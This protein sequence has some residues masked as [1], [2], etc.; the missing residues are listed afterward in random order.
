MAC[1][2]Y[3]AGDV[4]GFAVD[5]S[6]NPARVTI[7]K[8]GNE[9]GT[10]EVSLSISSDE[11]IPAISFDNAQGTNVTYQTYEGAFDYAIP[12]GYEALS[13]SVGFSHTEFMS[14]LGY[15]DKTTNNP[16]EYTDNIMDFPIFKR[17]VTI[18]FES[19]SN[20][21]FG[22]IKVANYDGS[23]DHWLQRSW[24]GRGVRLYY[25]NKGWAREDFRLISSVICHEVIATSQEV[26]TLKLRDKSAL[27]SNPIKLNRYSSRTTTEGDLIPLCYGHCLQITP[28]LIDASIGKYQVHDGEI[29]EIIAVY[30]RGYEL[31]TSQYT[32]DLEAGTF[33]LLQSND[34]TI[35]CDV[36]GSK[37]PDMQGGG[38]STCGATIFWGR[39]VSNQHILTVGNYPTTQLITSNGYG[40]LRSSYSHVKK[41]YGKY[42]VHF[43]IGAGS[44][45]SPLGGSDSIYVGFTN[46]QSSEYSI[47]NGSN[48]FSLCSD[49]TS[50]SN[51]ITGLGHT[52]V[53]G[54][55]ITF[56]LDIDNQT[57]EYKINNG[58]AQPL[59]DGD[60]GS[61]YIVVSVSDGYSVEVDCAHTF[62]PATVGFEDCWD[63]ASANPTYSNTV[64]NVIFDILARKSD[65]SYSD[66][67]LVSLS[68]FDSAY[69]GY[70]MGIYITEETPINTL[71]DSLMNSFNGF[72]AFNRE[73]KVTFHRIIDPQEEPPSDTLILEDDIKVNR[74]VYKNRI[75]PYDSITVG[76]QRHWTVQNKD[77]LAGALID[78]ES[79][80]RYD[81]NGR[82]IY[83][84]S[85]VIFGNPYADSIDPGLADSLTKEYRYT[86]VTNDNTKLHHALSQQKNPWNTYLISES[87]ARTIANTKLELH[88]RILSIY[89]VEVD[90]RLP[91]INIGDIITIQAPRFGFDDGVNVM[92]IGFAESYNNNKTYLEVWTP[93]NVVVEEVVVPPEEPPPEQGE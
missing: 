84:G 69:S 12:S 7:Y 9:L 32:V 53:V 61:V 66:F 71:L 47:P 23:K 81:E 43:K 42:T 56:L 25:G 79:E 60:I 54:D 36:R 20:Q 2:E 65:I 27:L 1:I 67:D 10:Y 44:S 76:Y 17:S 26:I 78:A 63:S 13:S 29:Q 4:L 6:V 62:Y 86:T 70:D 73:G 39:D 58:P 80:E 21:T 75:L 77:D 11:L 30:D 83:N 3:E 28:K 88:S 41:Y 52:F 72:W 90:R 31:E 38:S 19:K 50:Y 46:A 15:I 93:T 87:R 45:S 85:V 40:T 55:V 37:H 14:T 22:D 34:G 16:D 18:G 82:L 68:A 64:G 89:I 8:N 74:L 57:L 49:G 92:V 91:N 33:T 59:N 48:D 51:N 35:T 5:H 24:N